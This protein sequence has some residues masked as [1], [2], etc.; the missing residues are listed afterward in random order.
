MEPRR[1]LDQVVPRTTAVAE[2]IDR[3]RL[4][5]PTPCS[6][7]DIAGVLTHMITLGG[8][9]AHLFRGEIPT[10]PE[11]PRADAVL[12]KHFSRTMEDLLDAV[13]SPG[14]MERVITAPVG[15]MPGETFA[16]LVALDGLIHGW[17]LA[18]A[19]GQ[20]YTIDDDVVVAV[21]QFARGAITREMRDNGLFAD[22][23]C[24]PP[25]ASP[26]ERLVAFSG[27]AV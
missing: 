10:E 25:W 9:F 16:R 21:D 23:T 12:V 19:T 13:H 6:E 27:R 18:Q 26:L 14:S 24:P 22:P 11:S 5:D 20:S 2:Q 7:F 3:A 17:D 4:H 15:E 8:Q 1:Q